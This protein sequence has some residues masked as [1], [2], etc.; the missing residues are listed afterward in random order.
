MAQLVAAASTK[1]TTAAVLPD[2]HF[3]AG[4]QLLHLERPP[5]LQL[6]HLCPLSSP[7]LQHDMQ[8]LLLQ[9][10]A[11]AVFPQVRLLL[12]LL[13]W[14]P[15]AGQCCLCRQVLQLLSEPEVPLVEVILI[16]LI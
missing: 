1:L 12:L 11:A 5:L 6:Q 13:M 4:R 3:P 9:G 2:V 14:A 16:Q 8:L 10:Y 15:C 7:T